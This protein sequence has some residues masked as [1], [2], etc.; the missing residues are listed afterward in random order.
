MKIL[1]K[2]EN[3]F[4]ILINYKIDDYGNLRFYKKEGNKYILK[5]EIKN[6]KLVSDI[7]FDKS[8]TKLFCIS[9]GFI[10]VF[11]E[12]DK[13]NYS[14]IKEINIPEFNTLSNINGPF[15][16]HGFDAYGYNNRMLLLEDKN[17]LI[18]KEQKKL[19][20]LNIS[21]NYKLYKIYKEDNKD[22]SDIFSIDKS[23]ENKIIVI[24]DLIKYSDILSIDRY[25]EDKIIAICNLSS[26]KVISINE[27]KVLKYI[28]DFNEEKDFNFR[29]IKT[30]LEK[31]IIILGGTYFEQKTYS[32]AII[33]ILRLDNLEIIQTIKLPQYE[34]L[35]GIYILKNGLI[36]TI[37]TSGIKLWSI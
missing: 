21:D 37:F 16:D 27:N 28:K 32:G 25:D 1:I 15:E 3:T 5:H 31:N 13:G 34:W 11:K 24:N 33:Q 7:I 12:D 2:D 14:K 22:H 19:S 17:I 8:K 10:K 29:I 23:N 26:L 20:F 4:I 6:E 9:K 18:V 35:N 30:Y 36:A